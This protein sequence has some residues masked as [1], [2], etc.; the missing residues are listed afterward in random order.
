[1]FPD[2]I[3]HLVCA[4]ELWIAADNRLI[5]FAVIRI[6]DEVS[7]DLQHTILCKSSLNHGQQRADTV[8]NLV[9]VIR[10]I[11]R[12]IELVRREDA[13]E[14]GVGPITDDR[15]EAILHELGNVTGVTDGNLLPS[16]MDSSVLF[17]SRFELADRNRD[18]VDKHK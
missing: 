16:V 1:M 13:S 3:E 2:V 15:E 18:A 9:G 8:G 14:P 5:L 7:K 11:P 12:V 6:E 17:D 10:L 4:K